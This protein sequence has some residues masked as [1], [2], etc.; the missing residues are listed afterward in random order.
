MVVVI[1]V[2]NSDKNINNNNSD[3]WVVIYKVENYY[4]VVKGS[5]VEV[6]SVIEDK[7]GYRLM[8]FFFVD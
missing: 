4:V 8:F 2:N 5:R 3:I 7:C 1:F 6:V